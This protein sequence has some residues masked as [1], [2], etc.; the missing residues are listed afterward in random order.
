VRPQVVA[1]IVCVPALV[2]CK[3][4]L[5]GQLTARLDGRVI[6]FASALAVKS[7]RRSIRLHLSNRS[8]ACDWAL[9]GGIGELSP[10]DFHAVVDIAPVVITS[11]AVEWRAI[12]VGWTGSGWPSGNSGQRGWPIRVTSADASPSGTTRVRIRFSTGDP[13]GEPPPPWP[14]LALDG[15][16]EAVGCGSPAPLPPPTLKA[17]IGSETVE[18]GRALVERRRGELRVRLTDTRDCSGA[19]EG[20]DDL[21]LDLDLDAAGRPTSASLDGNM[22]EPASYFSDEL[23]SLKL[24]LAAKQ[25]TV[26]GRFAGHTIQPRRDVAVRFAGFAAITT[27]PDAR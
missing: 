17:T 8:Q 19:S 11:G 1:V 13:P 23:P 20:G 9:G 16:L 14:P 27:C 6:T 7:D 24:D 22:I 18:I 25:V 10:G 4:G 12:G 15:D 2:A 5:R 26:S 3:P 21:A